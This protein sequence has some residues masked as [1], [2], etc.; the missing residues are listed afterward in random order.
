M[1]A[2]RAGA[3]GDAA[4]R[5][6]FIAGAVFL[7]LGAALSLFT[8]LQLVFPGLAGDVAFLS[9]GRTRPMGTNTILYGWLMLAQIG[10]AYYLLPRM[11][12]TALAWGRAARA[13][14]LLG[15]A[16]LLG[17]LYAL[18]ISHNKGREYLEFTL[19]ANA[20]LFLA[21]VTAAVIITRTVQQA[22]R[23]PL[24]TV[25]WFIVGSSWW[26]VLVFLAGA[27][28]NIGGVNSAIQT[29]FFH[30]G[31]FGL[32]LAAGGIGILYYLIPAITGRE[33]P[34]P[35]RLT[36]VGFW[37][38][39]FA[40]SWTGQSALVF[41]PGP[42]WLETVAAA[43]SIALLVPVL[44]VLTDLA[45]SLRGRWDLL[46]ASLPLQFAVA[47]IAFFA[48]LPLVNLFMALRSSGAIVGLTDWGGAYEI[49][50]IGAFT[51]WLS[52]FIRF[53][54]PGRSTG[55]TRFH[56]WATIAGVG[57]VA[58][59]R[60]FAGLQQGLTWVGGANS[61]DVVAA[62][63]GFRNS[64]I[65][66][67]GP[68]WIAAV[69]L[70]LFLAGQIVFLF[71]V[72]RG[73]P[74]PDPELGPADPVDD[75]APPVATSRLLAGV[76]GLFLTAALFVL[77]FPAL[78]PGH[79]EGTIR[80]DV[81]RDFAGTTAGLGQTVYMEQGCWYCHTQQVRPVVADVGLGPVSLAGDY[82]N[83]DPA[84]LG[85]QRIG[86]DL[87]HAGSRAPTDSVPWL[88]THLRD[89]RAQRSWSL[90]PSYDFL[91]DADLE[92][93]AAYLAALD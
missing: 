41:G 53:V 51:L 1:D 57:L 79:S 83:D 92:Y 85:V 45:R 22:G 71:C 23:R 56:L 12:D 33:T 74:A 58:A 31:F 9:Y 70:A 4:A 39:A 66:L 81:I 52:A 32:F 77:V 61:L 76:T 93:L 75:P 80:G 27:I 25:A 20:L 82:V 40:W 91:S 2:T 86:P 14:L 64:V 16:G 21:L 49:V 17:G 37:S 30:A 84:L 18:A 62:G 55:W 87:M 78:E 24:G 68:Y 65:P 67:A 7:V 63:D 29:A 8:A 28:P 72:V 11:V 59:A 90:M 36:L 43:F 88:I 69:G 38:L 60:W 34:A 42:D 89:P 10:A 54:R 19:W 13:S 50:A 6:H 35:S 26:A 46:R 44:A 15:G 47:G 73:T 48:L 5:D 3:A